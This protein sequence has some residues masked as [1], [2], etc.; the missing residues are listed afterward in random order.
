MIVLLPLFYEAAGLAPPE[1]P[2]QVKMEVK[3]K[4]TGKEITVR[5]QVR[6]MARRVGVRRVRVWLEDYGRCQSPG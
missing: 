6:V 1:N 5:V 3:S 4:S 2:N